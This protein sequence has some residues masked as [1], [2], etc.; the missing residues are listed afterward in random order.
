M[1][2]ISISIFLLYCKINVTMKNYKIHLEG[3]NACFLLYIYFMN[4]LNFLNI[5]MDINIFINLKTRQFREN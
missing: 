5:F 4:F 3:L 1:N 2:S